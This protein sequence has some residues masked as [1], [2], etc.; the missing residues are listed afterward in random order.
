MFRYEAAQDGQQSFEGH[1][2]YRLGQLFRRAFSALIANWSVQLKQGRSRFYIL[3]R[4]QELFLLLSLG[5]LF[6]RDFIFL[7]NSILDTIICQPLR[8]LLLTA[9][10]ALLCPSLAQVF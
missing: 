6:L 7:E 10:K 4:Y 2:T 8:V 1:F 3:H 9:M 5:V